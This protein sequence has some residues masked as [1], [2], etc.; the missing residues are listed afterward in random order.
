MGATQIGFENGAKVMGTLNE[1]SGTV[2]MILDEL[3]ALF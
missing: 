3:T 2:N 1:I